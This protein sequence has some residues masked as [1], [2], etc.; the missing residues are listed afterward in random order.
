MISAC[1]LAEAA[2]AIEDPN[3]NHDEWCGGKIRENRK[4]EKK[5]VKI[6]EMKKK[7]W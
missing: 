3:S 4:K 5:W 2:K 7:V 1:M 6:N